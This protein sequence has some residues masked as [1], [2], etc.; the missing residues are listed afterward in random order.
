MHADV[1]HPRELGSEQA[2]RWRALQQRS[3]LLG[4]PFLGPSFAR[5]VGSVREDARVAAL[6]DGAGFFAFHRGGGGAGAPLGRTLA[7]YQALVAAP[8]LR[9]TPR[10]L[11]RACGLRS[12]AFDHMIV[13]QEPWRPAMRV[14]ER[15]P[16]VD[17]ARFDPDADMPTLAG[18]KARRLERDGTPRFV[19]RQADPAALATLVR[20]KRG[21]YA[22]TGVYDIF[23]HAWVAEL[24]ARMH[25]AEEAD[26]TGVLAC[27]YDGDQLI[28]AHLMLQAGPVLHSWIPAFDA[29]LAK[30]SPGLVLL[31]AV[32]L[33]A[34]AR[35]VTLFDFGK[36]DESYKLSVA[37][38]T[39]EVGAG[40][41]QSAA[42]WRAVASSARAAV[43]AANRTRLQGRVYRAERRAQVG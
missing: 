17:L 3:P 7:D 1:A 8:G 5:I 14:V 4:S 27:L 41:V 35:G 13:A 2:A 37:N 32:L 22:R 19:W 26:L 23:E 9:W 30:Q 40:S 11:L 20:W 24:V 43:E 34:P 25:A 21:Q 16:V 36:G 12:F 29:E 15:S 31:R 42:P 18:R 6:A 33:E 39:I 38:D 28:A 10:E